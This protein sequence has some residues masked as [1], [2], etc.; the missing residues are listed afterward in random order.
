MEGIRIELSDDGPST[1]ENIL[2]PNPMIPSSK[3]TLVRAE[4]RPNTIGAIEN[5]NTSND[6]TEIFYLTLTSN[7]LFNNGK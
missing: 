5:K 6:S 7:N 4:Q 2:S 1:K 3:L